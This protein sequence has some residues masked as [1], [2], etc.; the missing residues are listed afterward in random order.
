MKWLLTS[1]TAPDQ[2]VG[3]QRRRRSLSVGP[4]KERIKRTQLMF[5]PLPRG[6][7]QLPARRQLLLLHQLLIQHPGQPL[8]QIVLLL[9]RSIQLRIQF[10]HQ[11]LQLRPLLQL[12]LP[13]LLQL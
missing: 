3:R 8:S 9:Q 4:P 12:L 10:K 2:Q 13:I 6:L 1:K 5:Q 11:R 7:L